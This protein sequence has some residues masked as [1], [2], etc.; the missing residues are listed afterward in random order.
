[1]AT[2]ATQSINTS[3]LTPAYTAVSAAD[4][5]LP[6]DRTFLHVK[7]ASG[8]TLTVTIV[9]PGTQDSLLVA[10]RIISIPTAQERMIALPDTLYRSADGLGD[11]QFTGTLAG[12]TAAVIRV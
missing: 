10:D 3:G 2:F 5:F 11:V 12:C 1:M 7:N 8:A 9:T 6:A 4:R